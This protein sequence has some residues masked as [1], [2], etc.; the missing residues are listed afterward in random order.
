MAIE[1]WVTI[2]SQPHLM[3]SSDGRIMVDPY[4]SPLPNGGE[5]IYGGTPTFG[6]WDG[7]RFIYVTRKNKTLKVARLVCE[8]F[9]GPPQDKQVCMH[10]DENSCNNRPENLAWGT[11]KD[12]LNA[13]G[14]IAYCKS[15]TGK[16]SP[17]IKG[18]DKNVNKNG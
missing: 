1:S 14:F 5:R 2:P 12:N 13:P 4:F 9:N 7:S 16:N 17:A 11:Q 18:R 3:A 10:L 6:Q 8:A 15:R